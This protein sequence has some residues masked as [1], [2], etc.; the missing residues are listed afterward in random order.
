MDPLEFLG[1]M[2]SQYGDAVRYQTKFGPCFLFVHPVHVQT[3]LHSENYRRATLVKMMLGNGLLTTDG[4]QWKSV[5]RLMQ[6]D[7]LPAAIAPFAGIITQETRKTASAWQDAA[8]SDQPVDITRAMTRLT[9]RIVLQCLF[10]TDL[11]EQQATV[12]CDAFT[13]TILQTGVLS[14]TIFGVQVNFSPSSVA[15]FAASK[16][17]VD[18]ACFEM[19]ALRRPRPWRIVPMIYSRC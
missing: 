3:I 14:S 11:S 12:L 7:F 2:L 17:I 1:K 13:Q 8:A 10:S 6:K 5:R 4:Q 19:I 18:D 15:Q 9:L 16:K